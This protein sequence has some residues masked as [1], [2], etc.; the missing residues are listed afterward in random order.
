VKG[1]DGQPLR[2][3][4]PGSKFPGWDM[5]STEELNPLFTKGALAM[6]ATRHGTYASVLVLNWE[7]SLDWV[8]VLF[9]CSGEIQWVRTET[10]GLV[11]NE[12]R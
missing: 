9:N 4:D 3:L 11:V 8:E 1:L 12:R 7:A 10:L 6:F 5:R 2:V